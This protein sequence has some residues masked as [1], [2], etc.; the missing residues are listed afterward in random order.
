M[1]VIAQEQLVAHGAIGRNQV[2]AR[3]RHPVHHL[4]ILGDVGVENPEGADDLAADVR[5]QRV[6]DLVRVAEI[7]E[8]FAR[9]VGNRCGIDSV[10]FQLSKGV[11]Q[12]DELIA[13]IGSPVCAAAEDQQQ[14]FWTHQIV[15]RSTAA[16]LGAT[17]VSIDGP[18]IAA[19]AQFLL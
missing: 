19:L 18:R 2:F 6:F 10:R 14:A 5:K 4:V 15:Q 1:L 7:T 13:A 3:P 16:G 8:N 9:V 17:V 11:L 12:L